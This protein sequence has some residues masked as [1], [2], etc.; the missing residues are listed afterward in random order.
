MQ[1]M[2]TL[3]TYFLLLLLTGLLTLLGW[4]VDRFTGGTGIFMWSFF[5]VGIISNWV[6]YFFSDKIVL[7]M[8]GAKPLTEAEAPELHEM[9]A[10]LARRAGIPKPPLY[11]V[12]VEVPNAFATGRGPN[13]SAVAVTAG[14]LR[15]LNHEQI[16]GV[17]AHELSH[18]KHRDTLLATVAATITALISA[19]GYGLRWG[20]MFGGGRRSDGEG[21][22]PLGLI[23]VIIISI[24]APLVAMLVQ[25]AIS[26]TRE[27]AADESAAEITRNPEGLASALL[28]LE[29]VATQAPMPQLAATENMWIVSPL[30][31]ESVVSLFSTHPPTAKRVERLRELAR[32]GIQP[33]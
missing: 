3:K 20:A 22:N 19:A 4:A 6:V 12:P 5:A 1:I 31:G 23:M 11:L 16:E 33:R 7:A 14:L 30:K 27:Y 25:M 13:H 26:R 17:L 18:I 21:S 2:N 8:Y 29:A 28:T 9:V 10:R 24:L 15:H 32:R